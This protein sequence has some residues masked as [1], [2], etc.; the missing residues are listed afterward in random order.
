MFRAGNNEVVKGGG[1]RADETVIDSSKFK[2]KQ[3]MKLTHMPNIQATK[4]PNF[5][6]SNAKKA[7]NHLRLTF[8]NVPILQYF[9]LKSHIQIV[10]DVPGYAIG[11]VLSQLNL[12]SNALPNDSN[13]DKSDF[14]Q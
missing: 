5:L 10:I 14:G 13:L 6:T 11:G 8:I 9:D 3:S 4:K 2:N 12:D 7:F 1:G